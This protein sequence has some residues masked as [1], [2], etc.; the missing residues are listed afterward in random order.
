VADK[1]DIRRHI[2]FGHKVISASFDSNTALWTIEAASGGKQQ[3]ITA[4]W[5][6]VCTGYYSYS[7]AYL[8]DWKGRDSFAGP[9]FH[10]QFWPEDLDYEGKRVVVIGSGATA[11]TI[12][13]EMAKAGAAHV[14]MLQRSPT[15][16]VSRP[17]VDKVANGLRKLL[18][19]KASYGVVRWRNVLMQQAFF[20]L[21]RRRPAFMKKLIT[22]GVMKELPPD[23]EIETHFNP[24]YNPWDQRICLVPDADL[25]AAI[26]SGQADVVTDHIEEIVPEGI[27]LR[28]GR[29]LEA[30]V[31]V[32]ATG[33]K[34]ELVSGIRLFLD[35]AEKQLSGAMTYK[36][37]MFAGVPN[38]SY[39]FGYTNASWTLK[40]DLTSFYLCRLLNHLTAKKQSIAVAEPDA[41]V[42][43]IDFLDFTSSY[44]QR[45]KSILPVQG[46][47]AP[48]KLHQNYAR[49]LASLKYG[50]LEDGVI[51]FSGKLGRT[52]PSP[53]LVDATS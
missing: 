41:E 5:L 11:V 43:P 23:Y 34:L 9:L 19:P 27:R 7:E 48:W 25:F 22:K 6:H 31:I 51:R 47:R 42:K 32:A 49:D 46:D 28:S 15:Y 8:P 17:A 1:Y 37:M 10:A 50:K 13:P 12:V 36:G 16:M 45:A 26:R 53:T 35:G 14:T 39:S 21:A 33:L 24:A 44:V 3:K 18:G 38:L 30:D 52:P 40:A 2:R 20:Q 29:L 4:R